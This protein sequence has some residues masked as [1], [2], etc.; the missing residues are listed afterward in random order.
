LGWLSQLHSV[1]ELRR[2][3]K[4]LRKK[5]DFIILNAKLGGVE[6]YERDGILCFSHGSRFG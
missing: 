4:M 2:D 1:S 5:Q 3:D 6:F